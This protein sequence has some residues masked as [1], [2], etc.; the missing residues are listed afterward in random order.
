MEDL[1]QWTD[2]ELADEMAAWATG[3]DGARLPMHY[4]N[5]AQGEFE[6]RIG[7]FVTRQE[8]RERYLSKLSSVTA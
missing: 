8:W 2:A 3:G 5:L 7:I 6:R 4:A 1:K